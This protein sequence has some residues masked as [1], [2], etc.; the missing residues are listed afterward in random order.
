ML[1]QIK[2]SYIYREL[3]GILYIKK[4]PRT[5]KLHLFLVTEQLL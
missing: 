4:F 2:A 1:L 5:E 3:K